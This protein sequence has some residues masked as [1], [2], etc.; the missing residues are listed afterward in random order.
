TYVSGDNSGITEN[1]TS[2]GIDPSAYNSLAAGESAVIV[3]SYNVTDGNGGVV[4]QT[5][6]ITVTGVN[7]SPVVGAAVTNDATT[8]DDGSFSLDLL[9]GASDADLSDVLGVIGLTLVSGDA[10]GITDNGTSLGIDPSAYNSLAVGETAVITYS[11]SVTDG[12]GGVVAQTAVITITGVNDAPEVT[13]AGLTVTEDDGSTSLDLLTNASDVD[14]SDLLSITDLTYVSGDNSGITENGTS[15]GID[16]SAYNSLAAGETAVI[17]YSYNVTDG[18]GGVV[19]QTATITVTGVN[20]SPVVGA[21]VTN[22][23]TTEDDGSFSLDLLTGASDADTSDVLGVSSLTLVSG[24]ASGITENGTSLGIDPSAYISLAAGETAVITYNYNVTDGNG[25]VTAQTAVITITGV[26]DAPI[27]SG[28]VT[29]NVTED[30]SNFSLDLLENASDADLSDNLGVSGLTLVSGDDSGV[31]DNGTSLGIDLSAYQS[32]AAGES[33]VITF[34][35]N[36]IDGNG[37][38][39]AQ[40]AVITITGVNDAPTVSSV[41]AEA[42]EDG[43]AVSIDVLA[44][45]IDSDDDASSLVYAVSS[46]PSEGT[47]V[48]E[49]NGIFTFDPGTDFQD[50]AAGQTRQVQ[51]TYSVTDSHNAVSTETVTVTVTGVNDAP[52]VSDALIDVFEDDSAV[53]TLVLSADVDTDDDETTLLYSIVT[54]PTAGLATSNDDGTFTFDPGSDFQDL[55]AGETRQVTFTYTAT[56]SHGAVSNTG[57]VTVRV[58]GVNTAPVAVDDVFAT[59]EA[60]PLSG[61]NLLNANPGTVDSDAEGQ[62]LTVTDVSGGSVGSQFSLGAG[63]LLTVNSDGTFSYDPDGH[64]DTLQAGETA[65]DSFTYTIDDGNGGTDSATVVITITGSNAT[66]SIADASVNEAAG[67]V[68]L[69]LTLNKDVVQGFSVDWST[70]DDSAIAGLDYVSTSG[71]LTFAGNAGEVQTVTLN[72]LQDHLFETPE[73]LFVNID[74]ALTASAHVSI[75]D[76]QAVVTITEDNQAP[77]IASLGLGADTGIQGDFITAN[78]LISGVLSDIDETSSV[79]EVQIDTDNDGV[80]NLTFSAEDFFNTDLSSYVTDGTVNIQARA[81]EWD[82]GQSSMIYG[83]WSSFSFTYDSVGEAGAPVVS[84]LSLENDTDIDGDLITSD[85]TVTGTISDDGSNDA[86]LLQID[87]DEDGLS[88]IT[89]DQGTDLLFSYDLSGELEAGVHTIQVRAAG[90]ITDE[91][92]YNYGEWESLTFTF[93]PP[94]DAAIPVINGLA[95]ENDTDVAGDF[96]TSD[97]TLSGTITDDGSNSEYIIQ[98]DLD[99]DGVADLSVGQGAGQVFSYDPGSQLS[100]GEHT[101]QVRALGLNVDGNGFVAGDWS[102]ITFTYNPPLEINASIATLGLAEDT[103]ADDDLITVD[104]TFTGTVTTDDNFSN[105]MVQYDYENDGI[106]DGTTTLDQDGHFSVDPSASVSAGAM[107][108]AVRLLDNTSGA[109][110]DWSTLSFELITLPDYTESGQAVSLSQDTSVEIDV[111]SGFNYLDHVT[112][113]VT[114][115]PVNGAVTM[116]TN[117]DLTRT[118]TYTPDE[119]FTGTDSF[120]YSIT[121]VLGNIT[122]A[123]VSF[124]VTANAA[125]TTA[126]DVVE[127][128]STEPVSVNLLDNDSDADADTFSLI[129]VDEPLYGTVEVNPAGSDPGTVIYTSSNNFVGTEVITYTIEDEHGRTSTGT[130]TVVVTERPAPELTGLSLYNDTEFNDDSLTEDATVTGEVSSTRGVDTLRVQLDYDGDYVVDQTVELNLAAGAAFSY[131]VGQDLTYGDISLYARAVEVDENGDVINAGDWNSLSFVYVEEHDPIVDPQEIDPN[132]DLVTNFT[133]STVTTALV[134]LTGQAAN[135]NGGDEPVVELDLDQDQEIDATVTVTSGTFSQDFTT[136]I[137]YGEIT[138]L[139]R[140]KDWDSVNQEYIYSDWTTLTITRDAPANAAPVITQ[141]GLVEDT[142]TAGDGITSNSSLTGTV[143]NSDGTANGLIVEYDLDG[144]QVLEGFVYTAATGTASFTIDFLPDQIAE[145]ENTVDVRVREWDANIEDYVYSTWSTVTFTY[146][147]AVEIEPGIDP[148]TLV[149]DTDTP[150]DKVTTDPRLSAIVVGDLSEY[151]E[152]AVLF[153]L[154]RDGIVDGRVETIDPVTGEAIIDLTSEIEYSGEYTIS[155]RVWGWDDDTTSG[156]LSDWTDFT[157]TFEA[158][159]QGPPQVT[160]LELANDTDTPDDLITTDPSLTGIVTYDADLLDNILI[161]YDLDG[162]GLY[163]GTALTAADGSGAF[164]IDLTEAQLESGSQ[165]ISVRAAVWDGGV[166]DFEYGDWTSLTFTYENP[167]DND[168]L[169]Q[170]T[171]LS[172]ANDTGTDGDNITSVT[173]ISGVVTDPDTDLSGIPIEFDVNGDGVAEGTNYTSVSGD[174]EFMID[175]GPYLTG[176]ASYTVQVRAAQWKDSELEYVFGDWASITFTYQTKAQEELDGSEDSEQEPVNPFTPG[177]QSHVT[178]YTDDL[179]L[180][181]TADTESPE[182][183]GVYRTEYDESGALVIDAS[184]LA[185]IGVVN[186]DNS[187]PFYDNSTTTDANGNTT[188]VTI[189]TLTTTLIVGTESVDGEWYR[190][191]VVTTVYTVETIY[192][193]VDGSGYELTQTGTYGYTIEAYGY[194]GNATYLV[195]EYR[196]DEFRNDQWTAANPNTVYTTVGSQAYD[197]EASGYLKDNQDGVIKSGSTFVD[198]Q[199]PVESLFAMNSLA[200][201]VVDGTDYSTADIGGMTTS[202][203]TASGSSGHGVDV[204][205]PETDIVTD[206]P[207][208]RDN[209]VTTETDSNGDTATTTTFAYSDSI[210]TPIYEVIDTDTTT[211]TSATTETGVDHFSSLTGTRTETYSS[212]GWRTTYFNGTTES[213]VTQS[214]TTDIN[215]TY[216]LD[217]TKTVSVMDDTTPGESITS[218]SSATN[219]INRTRN[220]TYTVTT[221][222]DTDTAGNVSVAGTI[223]GSSETNYTSSNS[224]SS[225]SSGSSQGDVNL[226]FSTN[227]SSS[228]S[229]NGTIMIGVSGS[230]GAGYA[231]MVTTQ[232]IYQ[233]SQGNSSSS[234]SASSS[235]IS[236]TVTGNSSS[237]NSANNTYDSRMNITVSTVNGVSTTNGSVYSQALGGGSSTYDTTVTSNVQTPTS[238]NYSFSYNN[239]STGYST[240]Y[241]ANGTILNGV[242]D[243]TTSTNYRVPIGEGKF[244]SGGNSSYS[245]EV[246]DTSTPGKTVNT[247]T[248][249]SSNSSTTGKFTETRDTTTHIT[250]STSTTTSSNTYSEQGK[251]SSGSSSSSLVT[252]EDASAAGTTTQFSQANT[253]SSQTKGQ[254]S[255]SVN[256]NNTDGAT[257][258]SVDYESSGSGSSASGSVTTSVSVTGEL[259]YGDGSPYTGE[260]DQSTVD[261]IA[262]GSSPLGGSGYDSGNGVSSFAVSASS[263]TVQTSTFYKYD[264]EYHDTDGGGTFRDDYSSNTTTLSDSSAS[265]TSTAS[266]SPQAG[267]DKTSTKSQAESSL[268][269]LLESTVTNSSGEYFADGSQDSTSSSKYDSTETFESS[270]SS[271]SSQLVELTDVDGVSG[272][273]SSINSS[274]VETSGTQEEHSTSASQENPDGSTPSQSSSWGSSTITTVTNSSNHSEVDTTDTSKDGLTLTVVSHNYSAVTDDTKNLVSAHQSTRGTLGNSSWSTETYSSGGSTSFDNSSVKRAEKDADNYEVHT[275]TST[276]QGTTSEGGTSSNQTSTD[277]TSSSESYT[278][279]STSGTSESSD[280]TERNSDTSSTSDGITT[281]SISSLYDEYKTENEV[282]GSLTTIESQTQNGVETVTVD[283]SSWSSGEDSWDYRSKSDSTQSGTSSNPEASTTINHSEDH[284]LTTREGNGTFSNASESFTVTTGGVSSSTSSSSSSSSYE[285]HMVQ[286]N[287]SS[288]KTTTNTSQGVQNVVVVRD[289]NSDDYTE[290]DENMTTYSAISTDVNGTTTRVSGTTAQD[291]D[292]EGD[293]EVPTGENSSATV[294]GPVA[295]ISGFSRWNSTDLTT[296]IVEAGKTKASTETKVVGSSS[297]LALIGTQLN[298]D[299]SGNE[300]NSGQAFSTSHKDEKTTVTQ[301][302][303]V[304]QKKAKWSTSNDT[305]M[306]STVIRKSIDEDHDITDGHA[307]LIYDENGAEDWSGVKTSDTTDYYLNYKETRL[308]TPSAQDPNSSSSS[309]GDSQFIY[310]TDV[311]SDGFVEK[312][313]LKFSQWTKENS[314]E[315]IKNKNRQILNSDGE[316]GNEEDLPYSS[317]SGAVVYKRDAYSKSGTTN[318][319]EWVEEETGGDIETTTTV[320]TVTETTDSG[321]TYHKESYESGEF[322]TVE[323]T[324]TGGNSTTNS[325]KIETSNKVTGATSTVTTTSESESSA[326]DIRTTKGVSNG[327]GGNTVT[328]KVE[329]EHESKSKS[330]YKNEVDHPTVTTVTSFDFDDYGNIIPGTITDKSSYKSYTYRETESTST[331]DQSWDSAT[332]TV[333]GKLTITQNSKYESESTSNY[334]STVEAGALNTTQEDEFVYKV[335]NTYSAKAT[336]EYSI[337]PDESVDTDS[338]TGSATVNFWEFASDTGS[339]QGEYYE[340]QFDYDPETGEPIEVDVPI[341]AGRSGSFSSEI[342]LNQTLN[343]T[344]QSIS[345]DLNDFILKV[346]EN[347]YQEDPDY[348]DS[349]IPFQ[350]GWVIFFEG[351]GAYFAWNTYGDSYQWYGLDAND[352]LPA[353]NDISLAGMGSYTK[354]EEVAALNPTFLDGLLSE[355]SD[356]WASYAFPGISSLLELYGTTTEDVLAQLASDYE[357]GSLFDRGLGAIDGFLDTINPFDSLLSIPDIGPLYGNL[358]DYQSGYTVGAVAGAVTS[359]AVGAFGPGLV[360]C[361][362]FAQK[363]LAGYE[364]LDITGGLAT[365]GQSIANGEFGLS[366]A[367]SIGGAVL[368][369]GGF[370]STYSGCFVGDTLVVVP[371]EAQNEPEF[372]GL[373]PDADFN[374]KWDLSTVFLASLAIPI[375]LTGFGMIERRRKKS[376][377]FETLDELFIENDFKELWHP[378]LDVPRNPTSQHFSV[379]R[380][381]PAEKHCLLTQPALNSESRES[382]PGKRRKMQKNKKISGREHRN[383]ASA[384]SPRRSRL[385]GGISLVGLL[386]LL[387]T[388]LVSGSLFWLAAPNSNRDST[389]TGDSAAPQVTDSIPVTHKKIQD[390]RPGQW[391]RAENPGEEDDLEFG[392]TVSPKSWKLL[393]LDAPK[394]D[395]STA[396]VQLLRPDYWLASQQASPG[397]TVYIS[398]PECGIQGDAKLLEIEDCPPIRPRPGPGFQIVTGTYQHKAAKTLNLSMEGE[399]RPIG[400]TPNHPIWSVDREAFVRADS[401][402]VGEQLQTLNGIARVTSITARGPP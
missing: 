194:N 24:D 107:S 9:T 89:I 396:R 213:S 226:S 189:D 95:L 131:D 80:A 338:I 383:E 159:V 130:L 359:I 250:G 99:E 237:S 390:I 129:T 347:Q 91:D 102:S 172:L 103:G 248:S 385:W 196:T 292:A 174:G 274:S 112:A 277:G 44:A 68:T 261:D 314:E 122:T 166:L 74:N 363:A 382:Y 328:V 77:Q 343:V 33:A 92:G 214:T 296:T 233:Y 65:T 317:D 1:G 210:V 215:D 265:S 202:S 285:N 225:S 45:D 197:T 48:S 94:V 316:Y 387:G 257:T 164:D 18:N 264:N 106:V 20:D 220:Y 54:T 55:V 211:Q 31:T 184:F 53:T 373:L 371:D 178:F 8:E 142:D 139:A 101:I 154:D 136:E 192:N 302:S 175:V 322:D 361:G 278:T 60:T 337:G 309:S 239:G 389:L 185:S 75:L 59:D 93:N 134:T 364:I 362:S 293:T 38:V 380:E 249:G 85:A 346:N 355:L 173:L 326:K 331:E 2:L 62:T 203:F 386:C 252:V 294:S 90:L 234:S 358:D 283:A 269:L 26:N 12:N 227:A 402:S 111:L 352:G 170:V 339:E 83:G 157:F 370:K 232:S 391:V 49:G 307:W 288:L 132:A 397:A 43:A 63:A 138:L 242:L 280:I 221:V 398:V 198:S 375:G 67:T 393:T 334:S 392:E 71:T 319:D 241:S 290:I 169:P 11:Y 222:T 104:P 378:G 224:S 156:Y 267:L 114:T 228:D 200:A 381:L 368:S 28:I 351:N 133:A 109:L 245:S 57:T 190:R 344:G 268:S 321:H 260:I 246:E 284:K 353:I 275:V 349:N 254:Y 199:L 295:K 81:G 350:G 300:V 195:E 5:A 69:S 52:T 360:Q 263:Q 365:A 140:T 212:S 310:E 82:A 176:E 40:T 14:L 206:D 113:S 145:G 272:H 72:L 70:A 16:P 335:L 87:L 243:L 110:S 39:V 325:T 367:L 37:G 303:T 340:K 262:S 7:D 320:K 209:S 163:D 276:G 86:Y 143:T 289:K 22:D 357:D 230:F 47:V 124:T 46:D 32:L 135:T 120:T 13:A 324:I 279:I 188:E 96:I 251:T 253:S 128:Y 301:N 182:N 356:N 78:P 240:R 149:N 88:D 6:T 137:G 201:P 366:D 299:A 119:E 34:N 342:S 327:S 323:K 115:S 329:Y 297:F 127:T 315:T 27:V 318:S 84:G 186:T 333:S 354:F 30:D 394:L 100:D 291:P 207:W 179:S 41:N 17:V 146:E 208:S 25:G 152:T 151:E 51:F 379:K 255:Q 282:N 399:S 3:Y 306:D 236:S 377:P 126:D 165:T 144:D 177:E 259:Q 36:V 193:A 191:E 162:D 281:D 73:Q 238:R 117:Q 304:T 345:Y 153:D 155:L 187:T 35:Y 332:Q 308:D 341:S 181:Y 161:E 23:A 171:S 286:D 330:T 218:Y 147:P 19:A 400:T 183:A 141:V 401:L 121:D 125:P 76:Q 108:V 273:R 15:L 376:R 42:M 160:T 395:G 204:T 229:E 123:T 305:F 369:I 64:F 118:F 158:A 311:D 372:A 244:A 61:G 231:G 247:L 150:D 58:T 29:S 79:Y 217:Y 388:L 384:S 287:R 223:G 298:T 348:Y 219:N 21:V 271:D 313:T 105:F 66:L 4:A 374:A 336:Q 270:E 180:P 97:A 235:R 167:S 10:S 50:L 266:S 312:H 205:D 98:I 168:Q 256:S 216:I 148:V 56:D 258:T 116:V